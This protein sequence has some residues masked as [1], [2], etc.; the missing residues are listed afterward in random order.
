MTWPSAKRVGLDKSI[1]IDSAADAPAPAETLRVAQHD[2]FVGF[3]M[4]AQPIGARSR[5]VSCRANGGGA[6]AK[7]MDGKPTTGPPQ[8]RP[9]ARGLTAVSTKPPGDG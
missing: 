6:W 2:R 7:S 3:R 9:P 1:L 5:F 8:A 4:R